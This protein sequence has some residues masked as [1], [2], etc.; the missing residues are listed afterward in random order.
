MFF[1]FLVAY[2]SVL[3]VCVIIFE[4]T[5]TPSL[6]IKSSIYTCRTDMYQMTN[7]LP[8]KHLGLIDPLRSYMKRIFELLKS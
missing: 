7:H 6:F 5:V 1:M 2:H 3:T 4:M 8:Q